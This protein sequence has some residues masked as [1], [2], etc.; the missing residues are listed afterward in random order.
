M[1]AP[2]KINTALPSP[3]ET[4]SPLMVW[5]RG[6]S[7][8]PEAKGLR[9]LPSSAT[10]LCMPTYKEMAFCPQKFYLGKEGPSY[11]QGLTSRAD[12]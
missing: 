7:S 10:E 3:P 8:Q 6:I 4:C 9:S 2:G 12:L 1:L 11:K 5:N